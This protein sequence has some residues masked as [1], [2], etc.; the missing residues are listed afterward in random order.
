MSAS[1]GSGPPAGDGAGGGASGG[2]GGEAAMRPD[3]AR[4]FAGKVD[5]L[6]DGVAEAQAALDGLGAESLAVGSGEDN[7]AIAAWYRELVTSDTV[8]AARA[9]ADELGEL[10]RVVRE[11]AAAWEHTDA[12]AAATYRAEPGADPGPT[13]P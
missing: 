4:A 6:S 10:R 7:A 9:L 11:S 13:T 2:G 1:P 5:A 8:P 12:G 3:E